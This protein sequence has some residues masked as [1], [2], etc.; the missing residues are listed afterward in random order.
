[1]VGQ[2]GNYNKFIMKKVFLLIVL[3][4]TLFSCGN[5]KNNNTNCDK[6]S[7]TVVEPERW[8]IGEYVDDF[9]EPTGEYYVQAVFYGLFSNSATAGSILRIVAHASKISGIENAYSLNLS[10][11]EYANGIYERDFDLFDYHESDNV[12]IINK[13]A[14]KKYHGR[15]FNS[16]F[17]DENGK[18]LG[19]EYILSEEG[20]Y[21]FYARLKYHKIYEFEIDSRGLNKALVAAK[22]K[23]E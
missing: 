20:V 5:N 2:I 12:K 10:F 13:A 8:K 4:I 6:D 15:E 22:L 17:V 3:T 16:F 19:L 7:C 9:D 21:H 23:R 14:R 18:N 11:D 1:M